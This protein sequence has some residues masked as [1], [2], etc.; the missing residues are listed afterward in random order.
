MSAN[1]QDEVIMAYAA[2]LRDGGET[3][4][5]AAVRALSSMAQ[6]NSAAMT[7]LVNMLGH[8]HPSTRL[9]VVD[10]L[11][12]LGKPAVPCLI[13]AVINE[14]SDLAL[15]SAVI[16]T[17]TRM[18]STA[19]AA[20]P[21][22]ERLADHERLGAWALR[23]LEVILRDRAQKRLWLLTCV[24]LTGAIVVLTGGLIGASALGLPMPD[25]TPMTLAEAG[26][27]AGL[28]LG[29]L[30]AAMGAVLGFRRGGVITAVVTAVGLA[31]GG[32]I[33]G[34]IVATGLAATLRPVADALGGL[35]AD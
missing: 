20:V 4:R 11:A 14:E 34:F 10:A 29:L 17:L 15:R 13:T 8:P 24:V 27:A 30:G 22:L 23:A 28:A 19:A 21:V 32:G 2:V 7:T 25:V 35:V 9:D 18:E 12:K 33:A 5:R 1:E 16:V 26:P 6:R 3:E 31:V